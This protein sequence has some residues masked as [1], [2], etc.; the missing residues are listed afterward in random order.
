MKVIIT[1]QQLLNVIKSKS[2]F[3][4]IMDDY[5]KSF[6]QS[7]KPNGEVFK[8]L[9]K[10]YIL[11]SGYNVKFL[12]GCTGFAGVRT[13][14]Q[15]V[16]CNPTGTMGDFIY[17]IFH[18]IRHEKQIKEI[19]MSNPLSDFDLED[20]ENLYEQ[21]WEMELDAD[22]YAKNMVGQLVVK[23]KLPLDYAKERLKLSPYIE[24]YP[25]SSNYVKS[26]IESI[27][28][29]I[30]KL[31]SSGVEYTDIQDFPPIKNALKN[32]EEFF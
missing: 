28:K 3:D 1:E 15:V 6:P 29:E 13:K 19:K 21:Y 26:M 8:N 24:N 2:N 27:V 4:M 10:N 14:D 17:T 25:S 32:L 12:R 11:K 22:Q 20:F 5:I 7:L 9:I 30:K 23:S 18:E 31:K 16:I